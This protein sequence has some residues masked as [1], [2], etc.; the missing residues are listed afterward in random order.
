[1]I[2]ARKR[3][4]AIA[5]RP[6]SSWCWWLLA[7]PFF[8]FFLTRAGRRGRSV[9]F[10]RRRAMRA[11][12]PRDGLPLPRQRG[13]GFAEREQTQ[14]DD[15]RAELGETGDELRGSDPPLSPAEQT[16]RRADDEG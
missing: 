1:M 9:R 16:A 3:P 4:S 14:E 6:S 11:P 7:L 2:E 15:E 12:S 5:P 8:V 10:L 13:P